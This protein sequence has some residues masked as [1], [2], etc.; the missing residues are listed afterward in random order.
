MSAPARER[1]QAVYGLRGI[2]TLG[3]LTVHV[4]MFSG[5][6]GTRA[7]GPARPPTNLVGAFLVSGLPSFV[8]VFFVLPALYLYLPLARSIIAGAPRPTGRGSLARR[9][10]RLLPAY[11]VMYLVSLCAFNRDNITGIWYVL[12]PV[13]LLQVYLPT[14]FAPTFINGMEVTWTVPSLVQWYVALPVIAWASH[15]FARRGATP[16]LRARR[17]LLPV[18]VLIGAGVAWLFVVKARGWDNRMVFWWP[19]GFAPTIGIGLALAIGLALQQVS[20]ADTPRLLRAA[21]RHPNRFW[22]VALAVYGVNCARPFSVIG[23]DAIYTTSGLL[24]TYVMVAAFGLLAALPLVVPGTRPHAVH[25]FLTRRPIAYVGQVSYG[26]YLWHFAVMHFYLQPE[27]ILSGHSR[28][29]REFYG[30]VGFWELELAT[31]AGSLL[32]ASASHHLLER[33]ITA[34]ADR[35]FGGRPR[36]RVPDRPPSSSEPVTPVLTA[37]E[38]RSAVAAARAERDA[39]GSNLLDLERSLGWQLL[40]GAPLT[41]VTRARWATAAADRAALWDLFTA[42]SAVIDEAAT[43][44]TPLADV[45]DRLGG[46]SV[47]VTRQPPP[48]PRR[49]ITDDGHTRLTLGQAVGQMHELFARSAQLVT[50]VD[51]VWTAVCARLDALDPAHPEVLHLRERLATDPL[52]FWRDG[53]V[54]PAELD[55]LEDR[56]NAASAMEG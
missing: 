7:F 2:A 32:I 1:S 5:L 50:T 49:H 23:M 38:A 21:A 29:I 26:I 35:T 13:L 34:W 19:Q 36:V 45:T 16:A 15:R 46:D 25:T 10:S 55:H 12:R 48:L 51:S 33:P 47:R 27:S 6:L 24:V 53:R 18:P 44:G 4:A 14:P 28:P 30:T 43:A 20:P 37:A 52:S 3:L 31:L 40:A 8:G 22:L 41:G 56:I 42:Y 39:I 9:L 11:Y 54:D 17:L